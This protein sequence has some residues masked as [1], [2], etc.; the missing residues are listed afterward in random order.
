MGNRS[1]ISDTSCW[2]QTELLIVALQILS[3][4]NH[5]SPMYSFPTVQISMSVIPCAL[6]TRHAL[7]LRG[8]TS[9][10]AILALRRAMDKWLSQTQKWHVKVSWGFPRWPRMCPSLHF[11]KFFIYLHFIADIDECIQ[12]PSPC[13]QNSACANVPGSYICSCLPNFRPDQEGSEAYGNFSC[14]SNVLVHWQG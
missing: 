13:G 9:A 1:E 3:A 8:A 2:G 10:L 6:P 11:M 12:D 5:R 4:Q 14:K 7:I